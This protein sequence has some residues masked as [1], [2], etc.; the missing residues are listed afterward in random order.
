MAGSTQRECE[1]EEES[2]GRELLRAAEKQQAERSEKPG[3]VM[4]WQWQCEWPPAQLLQGSQTG[5]RKVSAEFRD[6]EAIVKTP[7][8]VETKLAVGRRGGEE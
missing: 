2:A 5:E 3:A 1:E 6:K 4:S 8:M 7:G